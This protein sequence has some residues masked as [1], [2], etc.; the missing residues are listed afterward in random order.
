MEDLSVQRLFGLENKNVVV[1]GGSK[2]IGYMLASAY[3]QAGCNVFIFSRKPDEEA[4]KRLT[5]KGPGKCTSLVCDVADQKGIQEVA[6]IVEK[7][8]PE[9]V[10]V[11]VNNSG[12]V[13]AAPFE[14]T[15]RASFD[16]IMNVN[17]TGL[18]MV[19]QAFGPLLK[20]T[21][22]KEDPARVINIASIDG[23][24]VPTFEEYAYSAS[25]AA[26]IQLTKVLAGHL[27]KKHI[28]VNAISPGLFPSKMGDQVLKAANEESVAALIPLG[29][30]GTAKEI[31]GAALFFSG[32]AGTYTTGANLHID[33]GILAKPRM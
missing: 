2:G 27:S 29:R 25:K 8:C 26:V 20:K 30:P 12:A 23:M 14:S 33:G 17:V 15:S 3:V 7:L 16:K 32:A 22:T 10:H 6:Q 18:F 1:T 13:W 24:S 31:A 28:T 9:G 11:L 19:T 21:A 5:D 4:A